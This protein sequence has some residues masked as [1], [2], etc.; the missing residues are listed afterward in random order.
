MMKVLSRVYVI[1]EC[2]RFVASSQICVILY[3]R[4]HRAIFGAQ[5]YSG[6]G[7]ACNVH[8]T[9]DT[10]RGATAMSVG[11]HEVMALRPRI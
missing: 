3:C 2:C 8:T 5:F 10:I 6:M 9:Q 7:K 1:A 11:W 4:E